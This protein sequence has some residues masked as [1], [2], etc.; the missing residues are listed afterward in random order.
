MPV[1]VTYGS[2]S[3]PRLPGAAHV[4]ADSGY[5]RAPLSVATQDRCV[6]PTSSDV[7]ST[8]P[9]APVSWD[10]IPVRELSTVRFSD[11]G[12]NV[13]LDLGDANDPDALIAGQDIAAAAGTASM[14]RSVSVANAFAPL[15]K[16]LG[17]AD[18]DAAVL[19]NAGSQTAS[20]YFTIKGATTGAAL[21]LSWVLA[22]TRA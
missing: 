6:V 22:G 1:T 10:F 3:P 17:Y 20:L 8:I 7:N 5:H 13:T 18:R 19:A 2:F 12:T 11:A 16:M 9:L 14:I 4:L 15:W 21:D